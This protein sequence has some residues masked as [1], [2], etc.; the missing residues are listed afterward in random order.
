MLHKLTDHSPTI[1]DKTTKEKTSLPGLYQPTIE[2]PTVLTSSK[3]PSPLT[4][5]VYSTP[6][7]FIPSSSKPFDSDESIDVE[8]YEYD[9]D[10]FTTNGKEHLNYQ[11][12]FYKIK[13]KG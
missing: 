9:D 12:K 4:T 2:T 5:A 11:S 7:R 6:A 1:S 8:E 13:I 10:Y 3:K